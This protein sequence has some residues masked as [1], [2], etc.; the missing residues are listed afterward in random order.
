MEESRVRLGCVLGGLALAAAFPAIPA[1]AAT[2]VAPPVVEYTIDA[3]LDPGTKTID[4][5]ERL[6][7]RNP[8]GDPIRELLEMLAEQVEIVA[9]GMERAESQLVPRFPIVLVI[10]VRRDDGDALVAEE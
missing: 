4:G 5:S 7:W 3:S 9:V 2:P 10:V 8:S 1:L 6:V